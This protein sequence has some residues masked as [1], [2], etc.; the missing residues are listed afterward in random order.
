MKGI[1][2]GGRNDGSILTGDMVASDLK[3]GK[4]GYSND[5]L[6]QIIGTNDVTNLI[7][8]NLKYN[9]TAG[10]V[11]GNYDYEATVPITAND[12][13]NG[14]KGRVNSAT[15]TGNITEKIGSNTVITPSTVDQAIPEGRY[16][17]ALGDGK[18]LAVA[19]A[20][21]GNIVAPIVI[22]GV[23]GTAQKINPL[24][25][26]AY[27]NKSV[28]G[29][30]YQ[31][32]TACNSTTINWSG[33]LRIMFR[34]YYDSGAAVTGYLRKNGVQVG[35]T[36]STTNTLTA[37]TEDITFSKNDILDLWVNGSINGGGSTNVEFFRVSSS[38]PNIV[39]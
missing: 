32:G 18:V 36:R 19:K 17:G 20:I 28:M 12:V 5:P 23:T 8:G 2:K 33:T 24:G 3:L 38:E 13:M 10:G 31:G 26:D 6:T 29:F 21:P 39:T 25:S 4:K 9:V 1:V 35:I 30:L 37:F 27:I 7:A 14:K 15:I 16:G 22:A 34:M 11:T